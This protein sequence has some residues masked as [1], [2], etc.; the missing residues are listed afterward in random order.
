MNTM[1]TLILF[2]MLAAVACRTEDTATP[3]QPVPQ[4]DDMNVRKLHNARPYDQ[5]M[6]NIQD[7]TIQIDGSGWVSLPMTRRGFYDLNHFMNNYDTL[8]ATGYIGVGHA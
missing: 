3:N 7:V 8:L 5:V 6:V 2:T 1:K 4:Q